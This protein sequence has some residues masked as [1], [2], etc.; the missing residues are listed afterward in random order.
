MLRVPT[1]VKPSSIAGVGV[2]AATDLAPGTVIWTYHEG[3]DCRLSPEMVAALPEPYQT[4][5]RHFLYLE[6]SGAYVLCGDN[7]KFM[8][9]QDDPNCADP[10]GAHTVARRWIR[11]GDELTCDYRSFD[12]ECRASGRELFLAA[13]RNGRGG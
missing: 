6:D 13:G 9:H 12:L 4:R 1:V 8:N 5:V 7:A 3:V 11:A 2:F 10:E